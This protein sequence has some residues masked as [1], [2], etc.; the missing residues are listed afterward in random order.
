MKQVITQHGWGLD[1]NFWDIYKNEFQKNN[2]YWQDNERGYFSKDANNSKWI[3]NNSNN[4]IKMVLCHSFGFHLIQKSLLIEASHIV[5]I[6]SFNNF[7]PLNHKRNLILRSLKRMEK[8]NNHILY[9]GYV[10]RI[11]R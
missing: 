2:W 11:H 8:K 4:K 6:N 5:L 3:K 10:K 9:K 1:Q 7:L